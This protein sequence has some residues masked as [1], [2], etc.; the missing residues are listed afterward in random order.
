[1]WELKRLWRGR[2]AQVR[3]I[4]SSLVS[5]RSN[6]SRRLW[7][8]GMKSRDSETNSKRCNMKQWD[9]GM[10]TTSSH[11]PSSNLSF[12]LV[13]YFIRYRVHINTFKTNYIPTCIANDAV[14]RNLFAAVATSP[15]TTSIRAASTSSDIFSI[16]R[17]L[18]FIYFLI[19][20]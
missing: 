3:R 4:A 12:M 10:T 17:L 8:S 14:A 7:A 19:I 18:I 9:S 16:I 13:N 15:T 5:R 2:R 6:N 1:M 11:S 20:L